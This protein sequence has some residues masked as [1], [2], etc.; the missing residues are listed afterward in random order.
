[1]SSSCRRGVLLV[2]ASA[3]F[4]ASCGGKVTDPAAGSA[5]DASTDTSS[6]PTPD[7]GRTVPDAPS[8]TRDAAPVPANRKVTV[9]FGVPDMPPQDLCIGAW[10]YPEVFDIKDP[11]N[12]T[13]GPF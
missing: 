9:L 8:P 7:G 13:F 11:P 3:G 5:L 10:K 6:S 2:L 4:V 12:E 1:M